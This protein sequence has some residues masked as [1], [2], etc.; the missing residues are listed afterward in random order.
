MNLNAI[1]DEYKVPSRERTNFTDGVDG[2]DFEVE[3]FVVFTK[4]HKQ[5]FR[6]SGRKW[7][8][9]DEWMDMSAE[10]QC[11]PLLCNDSS[12]KIEAIWCF[13]SGSDAFMFK[14]TFCSS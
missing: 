6:E 7:S 4:E 1:M 14:L 12:S 5:A 13:E 9:L 10:G 3:A 8:D 2:L 11:A